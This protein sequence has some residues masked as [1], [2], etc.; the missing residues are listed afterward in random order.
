MP[1]AEFPSDATWDQ[2]FKTRALPA[3]EELAFLE[4]LTA[5]GVADNALIQDLDTHY[6]QFCQGWEP[7]QGRHES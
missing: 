3:D 6:D 5:R 2:F 4:Y 7:G 1:N